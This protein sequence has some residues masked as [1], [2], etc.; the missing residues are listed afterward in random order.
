M[1]YLAGIHPPPPI[2]LSGE[3]CSTANPPLPTFPNLHD[4]LASFASTPWSSST[5]F[6]CQSV[7]GAPSLSCASAAAF[8]SSP[9]T[10]SGHPA[11]HPSHPA[12]APRPP[13]APWPPGPRRRRATSPKFGRPPS[14][15]LLS[16]SRDPIANH[17]KH[18]EVL[19]AKSSVPFIYFS[20]EL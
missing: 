9:S 17:S 8:C 2:F 19:S 18:F 1:S 12:G 14:L 16:W 7:T 6:L 15:L 20:S 5:S 4:P 11:S 3:L 13:E 10:S